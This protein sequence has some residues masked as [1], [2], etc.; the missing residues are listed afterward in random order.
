MWKVVYADGG[1]N[2]LEDNI[3]W[4][5]VPGGDHATAGVASPADCVRPRYLARGNCHPALSLGCCRS[6]GDKGPL[7]KGVVTNVRPGPLG[8][9]VPLRLLQCTALVTNGVVSQVEVL[10]GRNLV[11]F[12]P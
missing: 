12:H 2:E 6:G 8:A 5:V 7:T 11:G 1:M 3:I 9:Q 4:R 10:D